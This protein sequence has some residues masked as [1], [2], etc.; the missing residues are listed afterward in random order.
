VEKCLEMLKTAMKT[1]ELVEVYSDP[2]DTERFGAGYVVAMDEESV[3]QRHIHP[4]G[5]DDGYSWRTSEKIYRVNVR[6]RYLKCLEMLIEQGNQP[7]FVPNGDETLSAQLLRFA[8]EHGMVVQIE[9]HD[10]DSWNLMGL[11]REVGEDVAVAMLNVEG[12]EDGI[13][14]VR[15]EDITEI[16]CGGD[17]ESKIGRLFR[18]RSGKQ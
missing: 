17:Y 18:L 9:L 8:M 15:L 2:E 11:V 4:N 16:S 12:E 14:A 3:I 7:A 5:C 1:G 13:A 10:S 6:T